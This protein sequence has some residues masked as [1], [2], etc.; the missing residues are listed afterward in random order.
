MGLSLRPKVA[1]RRFSAAAP[2]LAALIAVLAWQR[3]AAPAAR[4][5]NAGLQLVLGCASHSAIVTFA[6]A[7]GGAFTPTGT[8]PPALDA[9]HPTVAVTCQALLQTA[10]AGAGQNGPFAVDPGRATFTVSGP[11]LIVETGGNSAGADCVTAGEPGSC[12]GGA[13]AASS[14]APELVSGAPD[15][16]VHLALEPGAV[17]PALPATG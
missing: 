10:G 17:L 5:Q 1:A 4:A 6:P 9:G 15:L 14:Q 11:A 3:G 7:A 13:P 12:V 16:T 8:P 2:L